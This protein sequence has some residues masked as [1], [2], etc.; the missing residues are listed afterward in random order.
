[1]DIKLKKR[2]WYIRHKYYLTL[3]VLFILFIAYVIAQGIGP[4]RL[5]VDPEMVRIADVRLG[6]FLEYVE[7]EAIVEPL[8]VL[9][10][11]AR[12]H[13]NVVSLTQEEGAMVREGDTLL[14]LSN[15][16]LEI[17]IENQRDVLET[18]LMQYA[19]KELEMQQKSL[20]LQ[21]QIR[22]NE[23]EQER[24]LRQNRLDHEEYAMGTRSKAQ[25]EISDAE[26]M[27]KTENARLARE[28]LRLDSAMAVIRKRCTEIERRRDTWNYTRSRM[29]LDNLV[30]LAPTNG[31]VAYASLLPGQQLA[32]GSKVAEIKVLS[33]YKMHADI[34]EYYVNRVVPGLPAS[35]TCNKEHYPLSVTK[36]VPEVKNRNFRTE[37]VFT[38][39]LPKNIRIGQN[40]HVQ[41]EL[42]QPETAIVIPR[43]DFFTVTKGL[44]IFRL[45]KDGK[46]AVRTPIKI[47][48]QNPNQYE[49][50]E[51]LE[52]GD[53]VI[54]SGYSALGE[55]EELLL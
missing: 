9:Q 51:G 1:M 52:A 7:S 54:V 5:R 13:G 53:R 15:P 41:V 38:D 30:V 10:V 21:Q 22:T 11:N 24:L 25:L 32:A 50:I 8:M 46:R 16:G 47:A 18:K 14:V 33:N 26:Y 2:P 31:Q 17:E 12:E 28:S 29:R 35:A 34:S 23:H 44:W 37:L 49:I 20:S 43:G 19:E 3:A 40:M 45:T 42:S 55:A 27:H 48:R 39:S 4:V 6:K 36:V